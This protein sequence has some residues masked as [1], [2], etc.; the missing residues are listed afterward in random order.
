MKEKLEQLDDL[1]DKRAKEIIQMEK[2]KMD[3]KEL[4]EKYEAFLDAPKQSNP[5]DSSEVIETNSGKRASKRE[6][7][8]DGDSLS[9]IPPKIQ[10]IS[11]SESE[12]KNEETAS[13]GLDG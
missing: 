6:S 7:S 5:Q 2:L 3:Y 1:K 8:G 11:D 4:K 13:F 9:G 10:K 12:F